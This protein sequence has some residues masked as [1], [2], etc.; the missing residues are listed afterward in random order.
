MIGKKSIY[1]SQLQ[2]PVSMKKLVAI[3]NPRVQ[4]IKEIN[5]PTL[6]SADQ[7][8]I[9]IPKK[10]KLIIKLGR[11]YFANW[12]LYI[13]KIDEKVRILYAIIFMIK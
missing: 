11:I 8:N 2:T 10:M 12:F 4:I 1:R 3:S 7:E 9:I 6:L 13:Q 5:I